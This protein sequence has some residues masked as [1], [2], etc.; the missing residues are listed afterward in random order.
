MEQLLHD[1]NFWVLISFTLFVVLVF[2]SAKTAILGKLDGRIAQIRTDI[3]TAENLRVE[4]QELLAQYQR[5]QRDAQ[6]EAEA[7]IA[8]ARNH[9][10]E[11]R[12][13]AETDLHEMIDRKEKQLTD[14]LKRMEDSAKAEIRAYAS[15]LAVKATAEIIANR[16]DDA[17][18]ARLVDQAIKTLPSNMN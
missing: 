5:K 13:T 16:L 6:N 14:R 7:I 11:I 4:A 17:G 9:A 3:E 12:K 1:T 8:N 18:N 10:A 15:E 2:K